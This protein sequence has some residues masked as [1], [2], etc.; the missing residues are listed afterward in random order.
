MLGPLAPR[1]GNAADIVYPTA[2]AAALPKDN[3]G[4]GPTAEVGDG[5]FQTDG[6][7]PRTGTEPEVLTP[8][9]E[10]LA[11]VGGGTIHPGGGYAGG[12]GVPWRRLAD[13]CC[14]EPDIAMAG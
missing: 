9:G 10:A 4:G 13:P 14:D 2:D 7:A 11:T 3:G 12:G 5:G 6:C 1:V 8:A